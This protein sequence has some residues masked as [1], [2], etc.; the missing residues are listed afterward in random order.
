MKNCKFNMINQFKVV[1]L[2]LIMIIIFHVPVNAQV[3][4]SSYDNLG[5]E[6]QVEYTVEAKDKY[7]VWL[8]IADNSH[9]VR[10]RYKDLPKAEKFFIASYDKFLEWAK[11]AEENNVK[12]IRREIDKTKIGNMLGWRYG[13]WW[14]AFGSVEV[15]ASMRI[16]DDGTPY[17]MFVFPSKTSTS[18]RYID[19]ETKILMF[20]LDDDNFDT[21]VTHMN[22]EY[23]KKLVDEYNTRVDIFDNK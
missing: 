4:L 23:T 1:S 11:I 6:I 18:N 14:F 20:G 21:F 17:C 8:S 7:T 10:L 15:V 12:D 3:K 13:D 9:F 2:L 22:Q 5:E 16:A 19:S